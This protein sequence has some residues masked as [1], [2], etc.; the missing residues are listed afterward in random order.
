MEQYPPAVHHTIVVT[1][2]ENFTDPD[3]TNLDQLAIRRGLYEIIERAFAATR[4]DWTACKIED[5]GDGVFVLIPADVPKALLATNMLS[6]LA[7]LLRS[8]N[9]HRLTRTGIRLR[10]AM[11]AGK[12]HYDPH[13]VTGCAINHAFR[14]IETRAFKSALRASTGSLGAIVSA[15]FYEEVIRHYPVAEPGSYRRVRVRAV[16]GG[17]WIRLFG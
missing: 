17:G 12:V 14:L 13:G 15:W 4:V 11:H 9:A 10:V 3:R 5:R 6:Q 16:N 8:Y 7:R 2:I 1:D